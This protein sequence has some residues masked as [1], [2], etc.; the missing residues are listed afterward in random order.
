MRWS[1][2]AA[3]LADVHDDRADDRTLVANQLH[4][5]DHARRGTASKTGVAGAP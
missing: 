5:Q 1:D 2:P 4:Q 3:A